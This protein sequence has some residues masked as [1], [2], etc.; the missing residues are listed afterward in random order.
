MQNTENQNEEN[1]SE[2]T[3]IFDWFKIK[4]QYP[5]SIQ[6]LQDWF[7]AR[8]DIPDAEFVIDQHSILITNGVG[9]V[10]LNLRDLY[11]FFDGYHVRPFVIPEGNYPNVKYL[12]QSKKSIIESEVVFDERASAEIEMFLEVFQYI[13]ATIE[14]YKK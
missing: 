1:Q 5:L 10:Y 7:M 9:G 4:E 11:D 14:H 6:A 12:I 8:Y 3:T 2:E 13:E